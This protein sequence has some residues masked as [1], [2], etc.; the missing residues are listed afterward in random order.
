MKERKA[1]EQ[2]RGRIRRERERESEEGE[3][4]SREAENK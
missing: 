2:V 3:K 1:R 4:G